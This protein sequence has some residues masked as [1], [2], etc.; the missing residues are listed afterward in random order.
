MTTILESLLEP[1]LSEE[2]WQT[3]R[4]QAARKIYQIWWEESD[5]RTEEQALEIVRLGLLAREQEIAVSIGDTIA[6]ILINRSRYFE[7]LELCQKIISLGEDHR[8]LGTIARAEAFLGEVDKARV[9]YQQALALCPEDD[10]I[11]KASTLGNMAQ[12]IAKQGNINPALALL[13]QSLEIYERIGDASGK[14]AILSIMAQMIAEQGSI[15]TALEK[16]QQSLEIYEYMG[17]VYGKA[18]TLNNMAQIIAQKGDI[19]TAFALL[20]QSL[21]IKERI[22]DVYGKAATLVNVADL[23]GETGDKTKHLELSLQAAQLLGQVRGYILLLTV[24][25]NLGLTAESNGMV[26]LAQAV[27][28]CVKIQ[29]SLTNRIC[30]I[31]PYTNQYL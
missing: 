29:A 16:Y 24:I 26:Y 17:K 13:Q 19:D 2:E 22:G 31:L 8:I 1:L 5:K 28:L 18:N 23:A 15:D 12:M 3:T 10:D 25:S 7:A 30:L 4:Q 21:E 27:W 9:H 11:H 6:N 14:A 20:Q